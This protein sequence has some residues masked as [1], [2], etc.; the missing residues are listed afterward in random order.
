MHGQRG[1]TQIDI[2]VRAP[3]R[4]LTQGELAALFLV[5]AQ[6]P[7]D[8]GPRDAL[9]IALGAGSGL[10]RSEICTLAI[11]CIQATDTNPVTILV[12]G[13]G[14][15][16][17][18]AYLYAPS[19]E[20]LG[21]WMHLRGWAPGP[22]IVSTRTHGDVCHCPLTS[23]GLW[24]ALKRRQAQA[25]LEPFSP[26]DLRR[27][28]ISNLLDAGV[29]IALAARLAGHRSI[30]TTAIYDRRPERAA[31]QAAALV[32]LPVA[33]PIVAKVAEAIHAPSDRPSP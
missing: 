15:R 4:M 26:H 23:N 21:R 19:I 6:D 16:Y 2:S 10:R 7:T 20:L 30:T 25:D 8:R 24:R 32:Q 27:T 33:F 14:R 5:C 1:R 22:L 31:R 13:K 11:N 9:I 12:F 18:Y 28:F 3:G 17:R 29:D